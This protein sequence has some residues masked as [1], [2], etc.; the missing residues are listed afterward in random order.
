[1]NIRSVWVSSKYEYYGVYSMSEWQIWILWCVWV[2]GKYEYYGVYERIYG[3]YRSLLWLPLSH[4]TY[5]YS[6]LNIY[7]IYIYSYQTHKQHT[8]YGKKRLFYIFCTN[9]YTPTEREKKIFETT[10]VTI[11][12]N[13]FTIFHSFT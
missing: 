3:A 10:N 6:V 11:F 12:Y 2:S 8:C 13:F 5:L 7:I 4:Q 1:M 9:Q